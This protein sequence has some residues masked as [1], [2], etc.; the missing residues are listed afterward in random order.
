MHD[1]AVCSSE[2]DAVGSTSIGGVFVMCSLTSSSF[3]LLLVIA[4][5]LYTSPVTYTVVVGIVCI[6]LSVRFSNS[7]S[8]EAYATLVVVDTLIEE[9]DSDKYH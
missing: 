2:C 6:S 8:Y 3:F 7:N 1:L 4:A 5:V 9:I